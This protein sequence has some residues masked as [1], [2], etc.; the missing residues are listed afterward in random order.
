VALGL[1]A[2]GPGGVKE[3]AKRLSSSSW[4]FGPPA[5]DEKCG[6]GA[7]AA[8]RTAEGGCSTQELFRTPLKRMAF[9]RQG[10]RGPAFFIAIEA[11]DG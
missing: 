1:R 11:V 10:R 2:A 5:K 6:T 9:A 3:E 4:A 7:L 8:A